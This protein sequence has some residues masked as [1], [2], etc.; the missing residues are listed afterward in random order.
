MGMGMRMR[1][2]H[3][4]PRPPAA[5]FEAAH[6]HRL[7]QPTAILFFLPSHL[8]HTLLHRR[9]RTPPPCARGTCCTCRAAGGTRCAA[10]RDETSPSTTG[11]ALR[12][13]TAPNRPRRRSAFGRGGWGIC[14]PFAWCTAGSNLALTARPHR[15][16][17]SCTRTRPTRRSRST[18]CWRAQPG[19]RRRTACT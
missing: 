8:N 12:G 4:L 15:A 18:A 1:L 2:G 16:G 6:S 10:P 11:L 14:G 3:S 5:P 17:L 7:R 13:R 19:R 9:G